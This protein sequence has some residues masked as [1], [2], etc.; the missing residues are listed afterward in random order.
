ML[1]PIVLPLLTLG[2]VR[3]LARSVDA[4]HSA[5]S[6]PS[7]ADE[8]SPL[9]VLDAFLCMGEQ[10]PPPV[11]AA[12]IGHAESLGY[13]DLA[14][15][16]VRVFV[17]P[18][19]LQA[20]GDALPRERPRPE[21]MPMT[22]VP[23]WNP[24]VAAPTSWPSAGITP[25]PAAAAARPDAAAAA[26]PGPASSAGAA[27]LGASAAAMSAAATPASSAR[28]PPAAATPPG[29]YS[30]VVPADIDAE[31]LE[32][33]EELASTGGRA[34]R[35]ELLTGPA[36]IEPE[37]AA[38]SSPIDGVGADAW[39]TFVGRVA[40]EPLT[41]SAPHH[42][43]QF[44]VRRERLR[45]LGIDPAT[46]IGSPEAQLAALGADMRDAY[47]HACASGL[48]DDYL[49]TTLHVTAGEDA[50]PAEVTLSGVLGVIQA[51][52]LEGAVQWLEQPADRTRFINT[53]QAF[54]RCNGVF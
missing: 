22:A 33:L 48:V 7:A 11:V 31:A 1:I 17:L 46:V 19:I 54:L 32:V 23:T 2:A 34:A 16:L 47:Q 29:T 8:P 21:A 41:F 39:A 20:E 45:E 5:A 3:Y 37:G 38:L 6:I 25:T 49:G 26:A 24:A 35:V 44:R 43:G 40:R 30:T 27:P 36:A 51:A 42:V 4:S 53:T 28:V 15:E 14:D 18:A 10:P 50:Q 52:G 12:A 9:V 13:R